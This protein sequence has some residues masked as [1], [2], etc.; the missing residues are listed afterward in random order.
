[1]IKS[2]EITFWSLGVM[3]L[4]FFFGAHAW[5]EIERQRSISAFVETQQSLSS[6]SLGLTNPSPSLINVAADLPQPQGEGVLA[7]L[8]A[9][10]IG[11]E[12]PV[13]YGT[14]ERV[15]R[16]GPGLIEGTS[17]PG[18]DGNV[19]IAAHRDL[20]FRALKDLALGDLIELEM[21]DHIQTYIVTGLTVVEP[22]DVHVLDEI[23][24]P[25]L[26]CP[27]AQSIQEIYS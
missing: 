4:L 9:S 17:F 5:G 25:V 15:L 12:L 11:L 26:D 19:A 3:L 24:R 23:G 10:G 6:Q 2:L 14:D 21:P 13:R 1:V 22:A 8:R 27:E 18:S 16:R 7:I 20:H